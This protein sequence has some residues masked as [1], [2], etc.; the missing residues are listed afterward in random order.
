MVAPGTSAA[1][2]QARRAGALP[3]VPASRSGLRSLAGAVRTPTR[4]EA[5]LSSKGT[6]SVA[7]LPARVAARGGSRG[8]L[9]PRRLRPPPAASSGSMAGGGACAP[10]G[11][12]GEVPSTSLYGIGP[13]RV[14]LLEATGVDGLADEGFWAEV[15][16]MAVGCARLQSAHP[17]TE[18][19]GAG[20]HSR[21]P[22]VASLSPDTRAF[23]RHGTAINAGQVP[24]RAPCRH[25][26][27]VG[28]EPVRPALPAA[29]ATD[30]GRSYRRRC[31]R[32]TARRRI[33]AA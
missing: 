1:S 2:P 13:C 26:K 27:G 22:H 3:V 21:Q 9:M 20:V 31:A 17:R 6:L 32:M 28:R 18:R 12:G 23:T 7:A 4:G 11:L 16:F 33:T 14:P 5:L 24:T 30:A 10:C 25:A 19:A 29:A 8:N 15:V